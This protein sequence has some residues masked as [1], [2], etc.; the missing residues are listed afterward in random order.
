MTH[1]S[2]CIQIRTQTY[3]F[4][5]SHSSL[6][7]AL[8]DAFD[9]C[10]FWPQTS[11]QFDG[12]VHSI[13]SSMFLWAASARFL[14]IK[15]NQLQNNYKY[16][17]P[18]FRKHSELKTNNSKTA[19]SALPSEDFPHCALFLNASNFFLFQRVLEND[20]NVEE[21]NEEEDLEEDIPKRK[22]RTRGRVSWGC[23]EGGKRSGRRGACQTTGPQ[24]QNPAAAG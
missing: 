10:L 14:S 8:R 19:P 17:I 23:Q 22:N 3:L 12:R 24:I 21:G 2:I 11:C 1:F 7:V 16:H 18:R 15:K 5:F 20:E 9:V 6:N 4:S 13:H